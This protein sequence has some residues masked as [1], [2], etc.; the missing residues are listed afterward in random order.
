MIGAMRAFRCPSCGAPK[1]EAGTSRCLYCETISDRAGQVLTE[2]QSEMR[3]FYDTSLLSNCATI[4]F[5]GHE[6]ISDMV[7]RTQAIGRMISI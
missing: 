6:S 2:T 5:Y 1:P 3:E 7:R 4:S